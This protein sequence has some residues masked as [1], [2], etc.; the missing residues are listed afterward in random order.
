MDRAK[1]LALLNGH[2][3]VRLTSHG[4]G[5]RTQL[6]FRIDHPDGYAVLDRS[7][8]LLEGRVSDE[9]LLAMASEVMDSISDLIQEERRGN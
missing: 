1:V 2:R 5:S 4:C 8:R 7:G 3:G 9:I 6:A